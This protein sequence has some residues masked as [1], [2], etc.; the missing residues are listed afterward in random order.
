[1]AT[2]QQNL[3]VATPSGFGGTLPVRCHLRVAQISKTAVVE[4]QHWATT[5]SSKGTP[6]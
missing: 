4:G 6:G 5:A 1:M 2:I 3:A